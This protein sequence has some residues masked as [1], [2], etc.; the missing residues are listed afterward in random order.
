MVHK[1][2]RKETAEVCPFCMTPLEESDTM[3]VRMCQKCYGKA[4]RELSK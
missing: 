2:K 1:I 4:V 3:R